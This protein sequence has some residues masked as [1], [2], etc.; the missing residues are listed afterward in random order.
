MFQRLQL[1]WHHRSLLWELASKVLKM[2]Y[3][4]AAFG[5]AWAVIPSLMLAAV[6]TL[7]FGYLVPGRPGD[8][9]IRNYP[10]WILVGLVPWNFLA[11]TLGECTQSM[12]HNA[13]VIKKVYFPRETIVLSIVLA[14]LLPL[15]SALAVIGVLMAVYR[16]APP[17]AV[18][19]LP[20]VVAVQVAFVTG[21]SLAASALNVKFRDVNYIVQA[22]MIPWFFLSGIFFSRATVAA[23]HPAAAKWILLNPMVGIIESYRAVLLGGS[24]RLAAPL[25]TAAGMAIV[26]LTVGAVIFVRRERLFA[27]HL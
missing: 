1:I 12:I 27:D 20:L 23:D 7:I 26:A 3:K 2:R 6:F 21:L 10:L 25:V 24:D 15:V 5:V 4:S 14:N 22:V 11:V 18:V 9:A 17:A 13:P 19:A 16:V 8:G